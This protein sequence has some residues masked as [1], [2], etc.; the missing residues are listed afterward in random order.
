MNS[1]QFSDI[2]FLAVFAAWIIHIVMNLLWF[3]PRLFGNQWSQLTGKEMKPDYKWLI[4]AIMGHLAMVFVLVILIK[5]T[6]SGN[7]VSGLIIGL[8]TW[9]G[10][11]VPMEIG[12]VVWEKIPVRLCLIRIGNQLL[13]IAVSGFILGAWQ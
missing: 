8:L 9:I 2:N 7:G 10:F 13:S 11:I 1:F 12:E 3:R 5:L 6:G 4:P